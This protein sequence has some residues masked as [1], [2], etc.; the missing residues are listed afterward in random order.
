MKMQ[1]PHVKRSGP[2]A[3]L[4]GVAVISVAALIS[5]PTA[6][7]S[8]GDEIY[9]DRQDW[10]F[11][12]VFGHYDRAQLQ[13]G[14]QVY[15]EVCQSCHSVKLLSYRNLSEAGGPEF[16]EEAVKALAAEDEVL[17]GPN[18]DGDIV[19]DSGELFV[20]PAKLSDRM[21]LSYPND[22]AARAANGGALPP[23]LSV[24]TKA[25]G[26]PTKAPFA[27]AG[28]AK[29]ILGGYQEGG[30]DYLYA[31]LV[32]YD[33]STAPEGFEAAEGMYYNSAFPGHQIAMPEPLDDGL[34][35][36]AD[37]TPGTKA[38]YSKDVTAFLMWA[39]EPKLEE[40]KQLGLR[41]M[42]YLIILSVLLH[43]TKRAL[44]SRVG[45]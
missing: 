1:D 41:V 23:D 44:W 7:F 34:V 31:L 40:R 5:V 36:Y 45:H 20:R 30:A 27:V 17:A 3:T 15:R 37:G 18:E 38:Q 21:K 11:A 43:L 4:A 12:G 24:I 8:A 35:E 16:P 22:A 29:D 25:R 42:L 2:I 26:V 39:A 19:D 13:R 9:V 6:V 28:W 10:S 32:G 14:F 33:E